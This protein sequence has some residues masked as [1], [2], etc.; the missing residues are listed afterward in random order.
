MTTRA[1]DEVDI[2]RQQD[3]MRAKDATAARAAAAKLD[4]IRCRQVAP[5][6]AAV[7]TCIVVP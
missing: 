4:S 6:H 5:D 2:A 3:A 7:L 1:A